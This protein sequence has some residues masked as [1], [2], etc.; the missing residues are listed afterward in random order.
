MSNLGL[1]RPDQTPPRQTAEAVTVLLDH[2]NEHVVE[3]RV[4]RKSPKGLVILGTSRA[5]QFKEFG[6]FELMAALKAVGALMQ[7]GIHVP[8]K[9]GSDERA[10]LWVPLDRV[11]FRIAPLPK[12]ADVV[13]KAADPLE[14]PKTF[15]DFPREGEAAPP[16][17]G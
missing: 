11:E 16:A 17:A 7:V 6:P 2:E 5:A 13:E 14:E 15:E 12:P 8:P 1:V 10:I 3:V 9:P 4:Q